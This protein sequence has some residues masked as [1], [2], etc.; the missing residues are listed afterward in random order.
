MDTNECPHEV[1]E[2]WLTPHGLSCRMCLTESDFA[3]HPGWK[4]RLTLRDHRA[5]VA[6]KNFH[7]NFELV[8]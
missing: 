7:S 8:P 1:I 5:E 2:K 6:R 4:D 3:R